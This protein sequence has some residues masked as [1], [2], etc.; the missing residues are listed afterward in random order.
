MQGDMGWL[1]EN[2]LLGLHALGHAPHAKD[3]HRHGRD[4]WFPRVTSDMT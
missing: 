4:A 1:L 2:I 3:G